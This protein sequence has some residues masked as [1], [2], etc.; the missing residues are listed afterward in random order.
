MLDCTTIF[1][2]A[3]SAEDFSIAMR[4]D[5]VVDHVA[6]HD[7]CMHMHATLIACQDGYGYGPCHR[8]TYVHLKAALEKACEV[9]PSHDNLKRLECCNKIVE[10]GWESHDH[11]QT[12]VK[13]LTY[14]R[15]CETKENPVAARKRQQELDRI[16]IYNDP[17]KFCLQD[18]IK[19]ITFD[20]LLPS[21]LCDIYERERM[22]P[23]PTPRARE[24]SFYTNLEFVTKELERVEISRDVLPSPQYTPDSKYFRTPRAE[25]EAT[26][27][28]FLTKGGF[29]YPEEGEVDQLTPAS[30]AQLIRFLRGKRDAAIFDLASMELL[31]DAK[32][33]VIHT[34]GVRQ[35]S[36][37]ESSSNCDVF[38]TRV[39]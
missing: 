3:D 4:R 33:R 26:L 21:T 14:L 13:F 23:P 34:Q 19:D 29:R 38:G 1:H 12:L 8:V 37:C 39:A 35:P 25:K 5:N 7:Y 18:V 15:D 20:A 6:L 28:A 36:S 11:V 16:A 17:M 30:R 22:P 9:D 10:H 24:Y 32:K 31:H 2:G 27:Q